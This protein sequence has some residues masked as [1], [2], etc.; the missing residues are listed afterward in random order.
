MHTFVDEGRLSLPQWAYMHSTRPAQLWGL[1]PQKGSLR[2]GTDAD[3]TVVDP[4]AEWEQSRDD[5]YSKSKTTPF[6]GERFTGRTAMT[7]VRG[8]VV[9]E[10]GEVRVG[11]GY[12]EL[13]PSGETTDVARPRPLSTGG[14][15]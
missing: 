9:Y 11:E 15:E 8:T 1:Y 7:V 6:N 12:G 4:D 2:V 3:F 5:L 10:D 13:V 14:R